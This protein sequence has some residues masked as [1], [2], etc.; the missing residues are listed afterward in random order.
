MEY[1]I[2]QHGRNLYR[3]IFLN[4]KRTLRSLRTIEMLAG[5]LR[6]TGGIIVALDGSKTRITFSQE[7]IS[8]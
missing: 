8:K 7:G 1:I 4:G 5:V 3:A 2:A 6:V